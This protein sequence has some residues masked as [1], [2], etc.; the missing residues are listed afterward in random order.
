MAS[1]RVRVIASTP[2][3]LAIFPLRGPRLRSGCEWV[4]GAAG[5]SGAIARSSPNLFRDL[6]LLPRQTDRLA[7]IVRL[8]GHSAGGRPSERLM[9]RLGMRVSDSTILRRIK[10]HARTKPNRPI[11]RVAGVDEWAW[12]KGTKFGTIVVDLERSRVVDLLAD[13]AADRMA[14][15]SGTILK[16]RLSTAIAMA[17]MRTRPVRAH[18]RRA[19][20]LIA[21]R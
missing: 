11:I 3:H 19:R 2:A 18:H 14:I 4:A 10:H 16:W 20:S 15:G 13:R 1:N 12:R 21:G 17:S 8:F 7:E 5:T 9:L 6:Q